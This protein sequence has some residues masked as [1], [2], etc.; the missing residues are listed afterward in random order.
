MQVAAS[1]V[2][3]RS[4]LKVVVCL[5]S[6]STMAPIKTSRTKAS[7]NTLYLWR[8]SSSLVYCWPWACSSSARK[9]PVG[10]LVKTTSRQL[11]Q[12]C[13]TFE[14]YHQTI[15]TSCAR[16]VLSVSRSRKGVR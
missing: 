12:C 13:A 9:V 16:W 15:L 1:L 7:P 2:S 5:A 8:S 10:S 14:H 11:R 3:S 6:G 4:L